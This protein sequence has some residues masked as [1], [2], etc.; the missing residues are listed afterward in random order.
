[1]LART[2][3]RRATDIERQ[4]REMNR[5]SRRADRERTLSMSGGYAR[6]AAAVLAR[7]DVERQSR[8]MSVVQVGF[9]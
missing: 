4:S 2:D 8:E 9:L 7:A 6:R 3:I 5:V 1:M